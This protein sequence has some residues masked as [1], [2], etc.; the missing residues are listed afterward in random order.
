M[1]MRLF[2]QVMFQE[3]VG[4]NLNTVLGSVSSEGF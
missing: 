2:N 4:T 3:A 1:R